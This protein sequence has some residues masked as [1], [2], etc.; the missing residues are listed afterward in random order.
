MVI[1]FEVKGNQAVLIYGAHQHKNEAH[2]L[3]DFSKQISENF[4]V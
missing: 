1:W 2:F 4:F 3:L